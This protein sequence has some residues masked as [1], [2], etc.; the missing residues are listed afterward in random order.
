M[1][2]RFMP[3]DIEGLALDS[4]CNGTGHNTRIC[5]VVLETS[6]EGIYN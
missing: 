1:S 2:I 3:G 6:K 4:N 5:Q